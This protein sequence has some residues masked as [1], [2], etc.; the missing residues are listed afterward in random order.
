L[1]VGDGVGR[2]GSLRNRHKHGPGVRMSPRVA[3]N[4]N[5]R[6]GSHNVHILFSFDGPR[7]ESL[8]S[9]P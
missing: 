6:L 8:P 4:R 3:P 5:R 2:Q 9:V 7:I 1:A